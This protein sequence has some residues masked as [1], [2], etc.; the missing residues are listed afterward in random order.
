MEISDKVTDNEEETTESKDNDTTK[1]L[2]ILI[3]EDDNEIIEL[4]KEIIDILGHKAD[5]AVKGEDAVKLYSNNDYDLVICDMTIKGGMGGIETIEVLKEINPNIYAIVS[6]GYSDSDV[7]ENYE[8][9]GFKNK[10]LKPYTID[11][12]KKVIN[13][14]LN[15]Q[16]SF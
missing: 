10:L 1:Q 2:K 3:L 15:S 11:G 5:F 9:Y 16:N 13:D 4:L 12:L 8:K 14:F 6:T 7:V